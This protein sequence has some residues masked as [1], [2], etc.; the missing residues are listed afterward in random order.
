VDA[1]RAATARG[2]RS[3]ALSKFYL[4][5]APVSQGLVLGY[6]G[7]G[8]EEIGRG[9]DVLAETLAQLERR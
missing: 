5:E 6:G 3:W 4:G 8:V 9:V 7:F 2:V 1:H